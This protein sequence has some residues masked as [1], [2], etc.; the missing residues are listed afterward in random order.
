MKKLVLLVMAVAMVTVAFGGVALGENRHRSMPLKNKMSGA[1]IQAI[2]LHK[3]PDFPSNTTVNA[4]AAFSLGGGMSALWQQFC[5]TGSPSDIVA[6]FAIGVNP[7][8]VIVFDTGTSESKVTCVVSSCTPPFDTTNE[9]G[10][11]DL[12]DSVF[13]LFAFKPIETADGTTQALV[14]FPFPELGSVVQFLGPPDA[15][16]L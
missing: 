16:G 4:Y 15:C 12:G 6:G 9:S 2:D 13:G 3:V 10:S 11:L 1:G 8:G 14:R 7:A 5:G